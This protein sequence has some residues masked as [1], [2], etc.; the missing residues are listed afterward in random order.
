MRRDPGLVA[1]RCENI[2]CPARLKHTL[3]H[4]AARNAMDIEGMGE[5]LVS[6]LVD[7][8]LVRDVA[9][10]YSLTVEQLVRLERMGEKSA[11]KLVDA[12]AARTQALFARNKCAGHL[13]R[14][15]RAPWLDQ[16]RCLRRREGSI[17]IELIHQYPDH[18]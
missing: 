15:R 5:V 10:I 7:A 18:V 11:E 4:F 3:R 8:G 16:A 12:I 1:W 14:R 2:A 17:A 6:Q 13:R 9:D